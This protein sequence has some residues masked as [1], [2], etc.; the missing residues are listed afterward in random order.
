MTLDT[1]IYVAGHRGLAG[2]ALLRRLQAKGYR[3]L[4]TRTHT[5]Y[6]PSRQDKPGKGGNPM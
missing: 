6:F 2:S 4:L 3:N 1:R 5:A